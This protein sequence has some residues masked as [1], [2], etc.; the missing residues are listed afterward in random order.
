VNNT[1]RF[2]SPNHAI[3]HYFNR[4]WPVLI[5][6]ISAWIIWTNIDEG[7]PFDWLALLAAFAMLV[8]GYFFGRFVE[9]LFVVEAI[10][11]KADRDL[12]R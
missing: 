12:D 1:K 2:T 4:L 7:K 5:I 8:I 6:S 10:S 11:R 3:V 9:W